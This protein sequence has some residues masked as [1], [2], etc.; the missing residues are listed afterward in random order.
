MVQRPLSDQ[1]AC[2]NHLTLI[3]PMAYTY[4]QLHLHEATL[5]R[6]FVGLEPENV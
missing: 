6:K 4:L 1:N 2:V 3:E 5:S